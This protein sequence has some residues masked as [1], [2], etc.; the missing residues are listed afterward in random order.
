MCQLQGTHSNA[1]AIR[2]SL[3]APSG[4]G[5]DKIAYLEELGF[6]PWVAD[7]SGRTP[8][9]SPSVLLRL[10]HPLPPILL[11]LATP[12]RSSRAAIRSASIQTQAVWQTSCQVVHFCCLICCMREERAISQFDSRILS[13]PS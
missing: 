7:P 11:F 8:L 1:F 2:S 13:L 5:N 10:E 3:Q 9:A 6:L 4:L 12:P